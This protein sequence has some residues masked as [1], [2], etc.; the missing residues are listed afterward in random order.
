V[1]VMLGKAYV[2][3]GKGEQALFTFDTALLVKPEVRRPALVHVGRARALALL[4]KKADAK[5]ALALAAKTE[6]ENADVI[7]L[8]AELK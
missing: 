3:L 4:G 8:K 1:L 5:A 7:K 2:G 6:P